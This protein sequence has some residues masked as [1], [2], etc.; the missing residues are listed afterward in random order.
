M[1]KETIE[2]MMD[3]LLEDIQKD[4]M[5]EECCGKCKAEEYD[6]PDP[7]HTAGVLADVYDEQDCRAIALHLLMHTDGVDAID[8]D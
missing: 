4:A 5:K 6:L 8:P 1:T 3:N 7:L 2:K